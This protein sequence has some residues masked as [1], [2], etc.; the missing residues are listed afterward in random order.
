MDI[1]GHRERKGQCQLFP[2]KTDIG[3][4]S[5]ILLFDFEIKRSSYHMTLLI[6]WTATDTLLLNRSN[7]AV[8]AVEEIDAEAEGYSV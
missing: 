4:W 7:P 3:Q 8:D 1:H 5:R 6:H 2:H